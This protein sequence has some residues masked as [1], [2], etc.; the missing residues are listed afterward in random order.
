MESSLRAKTGTNEAPVFEGL[1]G[2]VDQS[3]E[4]SVDGNVSFNLQREHHTI[5]EIQDSTSVLEGIS[6]KQESI[7]LR[8]TG[9]SKVFECFL[10]SQR[11]S[12]SGE[13]VRHLRPKKLLSLGSLS[14]VKSMDA[15]LV[16]MAPYEWGNSI[17]LEDGDVCWEFVAASE[18]PGDDSKYH[19]MKETHRVSFRRAGDKKF[20]EGY[21]AKKLADL[22]LYLS[23]AH[24]QRIGVVRV[25]GRNSNREIVY[26][27]WHQ[28]QTSGFNENGRG[29]LDIHNGRDLLGPWPGYLD[30]VKDP[31]WQ[32]TLQKAIYWLCRSDSSAVG[33][34][35][36]L[37]LIQTSLEQLSWEFFVNERHAI[38]QK[39]FENLKAAGQIRLLLSFLS[40][41]VDIPMH[42]ASLS[43]Y[44]KRDKL[45][46]PEAF[47]RIRNQIV[48]PERTS[49]LKTPYYEA[50]CLGLEYLNL[51]LLATF[52]YRGNYASKLGIRWV[53]ETLP[54]PWAQA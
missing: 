32:A 15:Y 5:I 30:K 31:D 16:N 38:R 4:R 54:V 45:D 6:L 2:I 24:G 21:F 18:P 50:Y 7:I 25:E 17:Q 12:S 39:A 35:G 22:C 28:A 9:S 19:K 52:K 46:G 41:P 23:F 26:R 11:I 44:A 49:K 13:R 14:R 47:T 1:I 8:L 48:H 20:T 42:L 36:G 37:V 27:A 3:G 10:V 51:V 29:W 34:D 53:G 33:V 43:E 40:I